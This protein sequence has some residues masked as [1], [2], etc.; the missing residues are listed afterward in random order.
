LGTLTPV[1]EISGHKEPR[2][3]IGIELNIVH[4]NTKMDDKD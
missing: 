1:E 4:I 2:K 3:I